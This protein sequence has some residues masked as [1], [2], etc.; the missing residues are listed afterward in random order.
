M[1]LLYVIKG[2]SKFVNQQKTHVIVVH[3]RGCW[4]FKFREK[5]WIFFDDTRLKKGV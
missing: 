4:E 1:N 5:N 3:F 2:R